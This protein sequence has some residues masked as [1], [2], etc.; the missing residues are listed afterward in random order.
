MEEEHNIEVRFDSCNSVII[1]R[2]AF[3]VYKIE[4][5]K[6]VEDEPDTY[7]LKSVWMV[8]D[9]NRADDFVAC[10]YENSLEARNEALRELKECPDI[11]SIFEVDDSN[12]E[13]TIEYK[14]PW[15]P[16]AGYDNPWQYNST[17]T[18]NLGD[19]ELFIQIMPG[20]DEPQIYV[21]SEG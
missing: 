20:L 11:T 12:K 7:K 1:P 19:N 15:K 2:S 4:I 16:G 14:V 8:I 21:R 6:P 10:S 17:M 13:K 18:T 5:D 9:M 3:K